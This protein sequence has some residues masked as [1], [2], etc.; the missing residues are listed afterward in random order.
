MTTVSSRLCSSVVLN[1]EK[2]IAPVIF[3]SGSDNYRRHSFAIGV[4]L[5]SSHTLPSSSVATV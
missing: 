1:A 5:N 3:E 2:F 4:T